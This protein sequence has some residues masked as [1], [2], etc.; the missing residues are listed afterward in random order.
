MLRLSIRQLSRRSTLTCFA[1]TK[2]TAHP[3]QN[4]SPTSKNPRT[5]GAHLNSVIQLIFLNRIPPYSITTNQLTGS[6]TCFH[7]T[8]VNN[9]MRT[10]INTSSTKLS[11]TLIAVSHLFRIERTRRCLIFQLVYATNRIEQGSKILGKRRL[12]PATNKHN[13]PSTDT[14][15]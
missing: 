13:K 12:T 8:P 15:P 14:L 7:R 1:N 4:C 9:F 11:N 2:R 5:T 10:E 6:H 3:F